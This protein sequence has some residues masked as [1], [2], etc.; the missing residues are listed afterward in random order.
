MNLRHSLTNYH[1]MPEYQQVDGCMV[2]SMSND[3]RVGEGTWLSCLFVDHVVKPVPN[4][5][6]SIRILEWFKIPLKNW[7]N[8]FGKNK[9]EKTC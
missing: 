4:R 3:L 8:T 6:M 2:C 7:I 1:A 5:H 9:E